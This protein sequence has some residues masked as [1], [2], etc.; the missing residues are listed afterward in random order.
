MSRKRKIGSFGWVWIRMFFVV[1]ASAITF[2]RKLAM[3]VRTSLSAVSISRL[4]IAGL[5]VTIL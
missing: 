4:K 1:M 5:F 2:E 3:A